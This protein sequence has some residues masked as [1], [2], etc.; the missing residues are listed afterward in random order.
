VR[1][2]ERFLRE[3]RLGCSVASMFDTH[4][5]IFYNAIRI[6]VQDLFI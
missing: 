1:E 4:L 2:R 5:Q 6:Y 3:T